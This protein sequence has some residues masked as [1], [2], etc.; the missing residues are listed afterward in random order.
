MLFFPFKGEIWWSF[1][2]FNFISHANPM[3]EESLKLQQARI[4]YTCIRKDGYA[5]PEQLEPHLEQ[6]SQLLHDME[7]CGACPVLPDGKVGGNCALF[8]PDAQ[9]NNMIAVSCS[10]KPAGQRLSESEFCLVTHFDRIQWS[11]EYLSAD[12]ALKP[13]SDTPLLWSC[14]VDIWKKL[15]WPKQPTVVLH[16]HGISSQNDADSLRLPISSKETLFSTPEDLDALVDLFSKHPYPET[17]IY[18]RRGHG[19]FLIADGILNAQEQFRHTLVPYL[20]NYQNT[21]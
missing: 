5:L 19:F 12:P 1:S 13:S 9:G 10:G 18:I 16:G 21:Q 3:E 11:V 17:S 4:K 7:Q 14:L 15:N 2:I 6:L 20:C 8:F